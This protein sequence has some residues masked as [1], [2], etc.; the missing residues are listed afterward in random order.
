M[1]S[2]EYF[3]SDIGY[4]APQYHSVA[5]IEANYPDMVEE[6]IVPETFYELPDLPDTFNRQNIYAQFE[7]K[8]TKYPFPTN[9]GWVEPFNVE[10]IYT[11]FAIKNNTYPFPSSEWIGIDYDGWYSN[12]Q[13]GNG[14]CYGS[15]FEPEPWNVDGI[16][17]PMCINIH[18]HNYPAPYRKKGISP[19]ILPKWRRIDPPYLE[20]GMTINIKDKNSQLAINAK[21]PVIKDRD[22]NRE[23]Y[24]EYCRNYWEMKSQ[25]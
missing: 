9:I 25:S 7:I 20:S 21:T 11:I 23:E 18:F 15:G 16:Y 1:P 19:D 8:Q 12:F 5:Y 17:A 6:G 3:I 10:N 14:Y 4:Y 2:S 24:L 22:L 13:Q